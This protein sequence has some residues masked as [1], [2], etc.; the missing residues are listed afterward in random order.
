MKKCISLGGG[1]IEKFMNPKVDYIIA[2]YASNDWDRNMEL[3]LKENS[4]VKIAQS[5]F[6]LDCYKEQKLL[7]DDKY[8]ITG[9]K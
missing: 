3:A 6:I 7:K 1:S 4:H 5:Q 2:K 8:F 9:N